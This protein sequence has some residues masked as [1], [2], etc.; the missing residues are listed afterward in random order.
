MIPLTSRDHKQFV[1]P[2]KRCFVYP[3]Y[4][5]TSL[6]LSCKAPS[7]ARQQ[8]PY[9]HKRENKRIKILSARNPQRTM[10]FESMIRILV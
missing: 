7:K 6:Y 2:I 4:Q 10:W 5:S 8:Q 9:N 1:Q 3:L